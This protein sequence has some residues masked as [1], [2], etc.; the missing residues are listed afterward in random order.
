MK[1][2]ARSLQLFTAAVLLFTSVLAGCSSGTKQAGDTGAP[3]GSKKEEAGSAANLAPYEITMAFFTTN[4]QT[5]GI[6]EVEK[7]VNEITKKKINATVK[8]V[9]ISYGSYSQQTNLMVASNE[10][11][12][13]LVSGVGGTYS[14]HVTQGRLLAMDDLLAKY[15]QDITK[16]LEPAF[17]NAAKVNGKLY[18][19]T[20]N[21]DLAGDRS[22]TMRKDLVDKY[23][24]DLSKLTSYN[25]LDSVFQTIKDKEPGIT[26]LVLYTSSVTPANIMA[27]KYFDVLGDYM[28]VLD[29]EDKN[30]KVVNLFETPKYAGML[31]TVRRW[32]EKG[33]ILKDAAT[34]KDNGSDLIKADRAFSFLTTSKPGY[35]MQASRV[36]GKEMVEY[37]ISDPVSNT[38]QITRFMW[39][40]ANNSKDPARAMMFLNLMFSD[41]D[42]INLMSWGIEGRDYVKKSANVIDYPQ[43]I[44]SSNVPYGVNQ[45]WL[46]GDQFKSYVFTG[47]PEDI[48][49]QTDKFNKAAIKSPALGFTF[50]ATPVKTE[51]AAVTSVFN[52]YKSGLETGTIDPKTELPQFIAKLK[53]AGQ[54]KIIAEKQKQLDEWAKTK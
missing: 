21:R 30:L 8:F 17:L 14:T 11:L 20:S 19:I 26:P 49:Q 25:D 12:D 9:P 31:D 33:Y 42:I 43:G 35:A 7:A 47:D 36:T 24:I 48:Y 44:N 32:Y 4:S 6:P 10:K 41:K 18:G 27:N 50:D 15:G 5:Q 40:I 29:Y 53:S 13:L 28:G 51:I 34:S 37:K 46:F 16:T 1:K 22:L 45:G 3:T 39:S 38:N 54:D 52:Q 2:R 23:K